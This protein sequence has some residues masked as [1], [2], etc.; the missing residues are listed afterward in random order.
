M[1][2]NKDAKTNLR[3]VIAE[4]LVLDERLSEDKILEL[5]IDAVTKPTSEQPLVV[6]LHI[7]GT[8]TNKLY[9]TPSNVF[10]EDD[11]RFYE[12]VDD[13]RTKDL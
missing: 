9:Q 4:Y 7:K 12:A 11:R 6:Q 13:F 10:T 5:R 2:R 8:R 1:N 3:A